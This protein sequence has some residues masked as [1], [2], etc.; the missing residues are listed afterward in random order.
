MKE[1][2]IAVL[3]SI[4][5]SAGAAANCVEAGEFYVGGKVGAALFDEPCSANSLSCDDL[6]GG[7]GVYGGYQLNDWLALEGGYDYLG[8]PVATYPAIGS[9][10]DYDALVQGIELGVKTDYALSDRVVLFGK[11][12]MFLWQVDKE[13]VE[14]EAGSVS[15][16]NTGASLMLGTGVEYRLSPNWSTRFEYQYLNGVG[17]EATGSSDVHFVTLG[18][19]YRFGASSTHTPLVVSEPVKMVPQDVAELK[20][21]NVTPPK[22]KV[23]EKFTQ[24]LSSSNS[25]ALFESNSTE[26][27]RALKAQLMPVVARLHKYPET[28]VE[29]TGHT[30]SV[31]NANYNQ[32]LSV[33]RAQNVADYLIAQGVDRSRITVDGYGELRPIASNKTASGRAHNRRV[34]IEMPEVVIETTN[35]VQ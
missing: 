1:N 21:K 18:L 33:V 25:E 29:I 4:L 9:S 24:V 30:D 11:G 5:L 34:E 32:S 20:A 19:N 26:L 15:E 2:K 17:N 6:S 8:G 10:V 35:P 13:A 7:A 28:T 3:V 27:S 12:G 22:Q 31:G 14:P 23:I 16:T